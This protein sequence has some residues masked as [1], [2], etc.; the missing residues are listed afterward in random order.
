MLWT[1]NMC[2]PKGLK[3]KKQAEAFI[4]FYYDPTVAAQV[5]AYV[6]YVCPVKGAGDA[7]KAKSPAIANNPLI[8]PPADIV[9]RLHQFRVLDANEE[10]AWNDAFSKVMGT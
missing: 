1:D 7:L 4:N 5:E 2:M 3:N 6:N 10:T 8:F 9:A